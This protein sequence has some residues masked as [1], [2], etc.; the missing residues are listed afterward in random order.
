MRLLILTSLLLVLG[1]GCRKK[2]E[3]LVLI[4]VKT[5]QQQWAEGA[6][7]ELLTYPPYEPGENP[8]LHRSAVTSSDGRAW[9]TFDDVYQLGQ[10]GVAVLNIRVTHGDQAGSGIIKIEEE[11]TNKAVVILQP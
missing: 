8:I 10:A 4:Q 11:T 9:F 7:V 6:T 3:T 1:A 5:S 2:G